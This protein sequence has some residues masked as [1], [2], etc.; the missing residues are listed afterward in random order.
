MQPTLY[1]VV[2]GGAMLANAIIGHFLYRAAFADAG[3]DPILAATALAVGVAGIAVQI[4]VKPVSW[5]LDLARGAAV[6][7]LLGLVAIG[8]LAFVAANFESGLSR[9]GLGSRS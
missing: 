5:A 3:Q 8:L 2:V 7:M 6:G 4:L 1:Q 9:D